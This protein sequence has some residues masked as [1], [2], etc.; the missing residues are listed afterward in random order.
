ME[1]TRKDLFLS[2]YDFAFEA[3]W[4]VIAIKSP[5]GNIELITNQKENI[6]TKVDYYK[7]AYN[8]DLVLN[9]NLNIEIVNWMF[10]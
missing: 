7:L 8:D 6:D 2:D 5:D 1:I 9:S 4:L 10:A 3:N